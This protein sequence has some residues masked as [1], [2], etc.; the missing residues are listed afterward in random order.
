MLF[1]LIHL[2]E[3][4]G[5]FAIAFILIMR[6]NI[7]KRLLTGK[8]SS[9]EKLYLSVLFGLFGIAGTYMGVPVQD[10][11]ANSRVVGVALGGI[12]GGP[13]VGAAAGVIAGGHRFLIDIGGFTAMACGIA[14]ILE[15]FTGGLLYHRLKR[16]PFDPTMAFVTGIIVET[17]QMAVLLLL[18]KP[19]SAAL[20]LVSIIGFP[21]ILI[22]SIGLALFV[23]LVSSVYKEKERFA[24]FQA[25]TA[26]NIALR[27]LPFL[28]N[29]L[30]AS[31]AAATAGIIVEMTDL[32]GVSIT[33]E[34][35]LLSYK[36]AGEEHHQPGTG[37][38]HASTKNALTSGCISTP[39]TKEEIGCITP[40]CQLGSAIIV[41]LKK[42]NKTIGTLQLHRIK[43]N[44]ITTLDMELANGLAH[45]FSNQLEISDLEEQR[46]L[47]KDAEIKALQAQ[48][49]PHF[50]FNAINTIISYTRTSPETASSLLVKLADFYRT[51]INPGSK[52][53]S[54]ATELDHCKAYIAIES[55]RFEDR[56]RVNYDIENSI[57]GI[58]LPPLI[59]QPLVE[60]ALKHGILPREEGGDVFISAHCRGN[61]VY[62]EVKDN[63]I[64][65]PQH[66]IDKLF[67]DDIQH[68]DQPGAGIALKNVNSRL[69]AL[70]GSEHA[71]R[72][73]SEP[74]KG[75][76]VSFTVPYT[77]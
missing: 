74:G 45:L 23:E 73:E 51:N 32:D 8:A 35:N 21:M 6:F 39:V 59:L 50:L 40:D 1:L 7:F 52:K 26:L 37:F 62:I 36:G 72:I 63:G 24:A 58:R 5:I 17:Q 69:F 65:I 27:T 13:L 77:P 44:G 68:A 48:I 3:R 67:D 10:A 38:L 12:L 54:L 15:G 66:Q 28:R 70:Y 31:S 16:Q 42:Q 19:F 46:K 49:N 64:G 61:R 30:T 41:P 76:I 75:T 34:T 53:V 57:A 47:V 22:N 43:E 9:H 56:I 11:I 33:D 18:A 29:G 4:L 14:T 55:A 20:S 2:L 60:N 71:L 25:Q